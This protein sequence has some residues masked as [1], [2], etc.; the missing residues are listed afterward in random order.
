MSV[1]VNVKW[2]KE[3]FQLVLDPA[4]PPAVFKEAVYQKTGVPVDR[5]KVCVNAL[6]RVLVAGRRSCRSAV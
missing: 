5:Q 3:K 4:Q 1:T 6:Y 2:G